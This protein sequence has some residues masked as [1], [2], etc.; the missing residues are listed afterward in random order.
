MGATGRVGTHTEENGTA[1][2]GADLGRNSQ[3]ASHRPE[4]EQGK[5]VGELLLSAAKLQ[6]QTTARK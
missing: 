1:V 6:R 2:R 4:K 3:P 5:A